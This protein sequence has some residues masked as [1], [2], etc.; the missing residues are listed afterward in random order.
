M[1]NGHMDTY[2]PGV[3]W[4]VDPFAGVVKDGAITGCGVTNMKAACAAFCG[5]ARALKRSGARLRGD[6]ILTHVVGELSGGDG[7]RKVVEAGIRPDYF[8]VGEP[9]DLAVLTVHA[10]SVSLAIN[11]LGMTGH[12]SMLEKTVSAIDTMYKVIERLKR[13]KLSGRSSPDFGDQHRLASLSIRAGVTREFVGGAGVIPDFATTN[14]NI[15]YGPGQ[16]R[17]RDTVVEDVRR[18]LEALQKEESQVVTEL[19]V[20]PVDTGRPPLKPFEVSRDHPIVRSLIEA[21]TKILAAPP[22]V[23]GL[24]PYRYYGTDAPILQQLGGISGAVCGPG[25]IDLRDFYAA[26]RIYALVALATC[27]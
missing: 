11:T 6:L 12:I 10:A 27:R 3:G 5:A 20:P 15:R 13:M 16:G 4:T 8:V 22:P 23:G 2:E 19:I 18:E 1:L 17:N 24:A 14:I 26:S 9:T 7:S 21:H 25:G